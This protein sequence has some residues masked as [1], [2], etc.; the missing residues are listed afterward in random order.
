MKEHTLSVFENG[1]NGKVSE[2]NRQEVIGA[3][4]ELPNQEL[5]NLYCSSNISRATTSR[6]MGWMEAYRTLLQ[7]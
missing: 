2:P 3:L 5:H 6:K 4:G 7:R 1:T